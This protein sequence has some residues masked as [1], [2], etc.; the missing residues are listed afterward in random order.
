[1]NWLPI[2]LILVFVIACAIEASPAL[3]YALHRWDNK[4]AGE[5]TKK[6]DDD[7]EE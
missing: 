3:S 7:V 2:I 1:M 5:R 6:R 4:L